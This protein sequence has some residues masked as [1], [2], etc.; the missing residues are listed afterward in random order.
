MHKPCRLVSPL[1]FYCRQFRKEENK[2]R[3]QGDYA[4]PGLITV[5]QFRHAWKKFSIRVTEEQAHAMFIK[6]GCDTQGLLPYDL[7]AAKL[8][9]SPAR[10]LAL[11]PEQ[12]VWPTLPVRS[13]MTTYVA[14]AVNLLL[15]ALLPVSRG[16]TS[17]RATPPS[18]G[19][20]R[21]ATAASRCSRPR[22]GMGAQRSGRRR[23][24]RQV[25]SA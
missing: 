8:L 4:P 12:K 22:T 16:R 5:A 21:T 14:Q 20:S 7:F 24:Q 9:G 6:Y 25:S 18:A 17:L 15:V 13:F 10:L 19:R 3:L 1:V 23:S 2:A 11:E